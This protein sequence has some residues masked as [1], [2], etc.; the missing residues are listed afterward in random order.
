[1]RKPVKLLLATTMSL[2]LSLG[3]VGCNSTDNEEKKGFKVGVVLGE[4]G[5][6]DQS[7]NQSS[8]EGLNKAKKELGIDGKYLEST[9]DA[10][11]VPNIETFVED[12]LQQQPC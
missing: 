3:L 10:D 11:Y 12:I 2:V 7:F 9:Q 8:L 5:A 4:G 1:M 6:N